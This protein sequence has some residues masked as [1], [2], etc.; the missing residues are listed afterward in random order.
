MDRIRIRLHYD[1]E[2]GDLGNAQ[3]IRV[4]LPG[5]EARFPAGMWEV[6]PI[7]HGRPAELWGTGDWIATRERQEDPRGF[8]HHFLRFLSDARLA[9]ASHR[10]PARYRF[11]FPTLFSTFFPA[12][13]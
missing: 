8:R 4:V 11:A 6:A 13:K 1:L 12:R 2:T 3:P 7:A 10:D 9:G 5:G